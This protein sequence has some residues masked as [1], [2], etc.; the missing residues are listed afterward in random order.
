MSLRTA[1][2]SALSSAKHIELGNVPTSITPADIRRLLWRS[3]VQDVQDGM[4]NLTSYIFIFITI[5]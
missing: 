4:F 1:S 5:F 3:K 2:R